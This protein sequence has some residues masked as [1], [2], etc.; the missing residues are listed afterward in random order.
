MNKRNISGACITLLKNYNSDVPICPGKSLK[1]H[2][3]TL[4]GLG[5]KTRYTG[6]QKGIF[7]GLFC[8][9]FP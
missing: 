2:I 3:R 4:I 5:S 1:I 9:L 7:H 6:F 8:D